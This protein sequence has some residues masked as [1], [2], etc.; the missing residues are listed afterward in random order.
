MSTVRLGLKLLNDHCRESRNQKFERFEH[1]CLSL[2]D[3]AWIED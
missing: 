1:R 3:I 2:A